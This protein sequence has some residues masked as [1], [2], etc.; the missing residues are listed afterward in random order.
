MVVQ[1]GHRTLGKV[2]KWGKSECRKCVEFHQGEG[3]SSNQ[4]K[5]SDGT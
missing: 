1:P 2:Q 3:P 5:I 4:R